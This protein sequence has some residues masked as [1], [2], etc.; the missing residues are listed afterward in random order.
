[1]DVI[2]PKHCRLSFFCLGSFIDR[3]EFCG[4][5]KTVECRTIV[6]TPLFLF[7]RLHGFGKFFMVNAQVLYQ[8]GDLIQCEQQRHY[9]GNC[10]DSFSGK[11]LY[12][13]LRAI[14]KQIWTL[15][16]PITFG[17][18]ISSKRNGSSSRV[19]AYSNRRNDR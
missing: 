1:M 5:F 8:A 19:C 6:F 12:F 18:H 14:A 13:L 15:N 10:S 7:S 3:V 17:V 16:A 11:R 9:R 4:M 2:Q